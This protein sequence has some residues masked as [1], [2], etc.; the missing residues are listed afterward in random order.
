[1]C[2]PIVKVDAGRVG[3]QQ[4]VRPDVGK[5][6]RKACAL[7]AQAKISPPDKISSLRAPPAGKASANTCREVDETTMTA[8]ESPS[9]EAES[10]FTVLLRAARA[11]DSAALAALFERFYPRVEDMVH[12]AL[13][14][15]LRASRPW[16]RTRF[17]TGDVV[18]EVFR[19]V[20]QDLDGFAGASESA[21]A[22]YL[23]MVVRNRLIDAI[24]HHEAARRDGRRTHRPEELAEP[25]SP[26]DGPSTDLMSAEELTRFHEVMGTFA[27]R[28]RLLLRARLEQQASFQELAEQLGYTSAYAARRAFY[29]TQATFAVRMR[30]RRTSEER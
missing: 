25:V 3:P 21:F 20:L 2:L 1:M 13:A 15:D 24:R 18:Q 8:A 12:R 27:E 14:R 23:A 26:S 5:S 4:P 19:S 10:D 16:L 22:G 7:L 9:R 17:S 28:E 6:S 11:G 30:Q 29:S